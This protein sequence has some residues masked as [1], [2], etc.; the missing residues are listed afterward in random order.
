MDALLATTH[1]ERMRVVTRQTTSGAQ[2]NSLLR[3]VSCSIAGGRI[4]VGVVHRQTL[5][6]CLAT[7]HSRF[8]TGDITG[9]PIAENFDR[10]GSVHDIDPHTSHSKTSLEFVLYGGGVYK[11]ERGRKEKGRVRKGTDP[12]VI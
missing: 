10:G 12:L 3:L 7:L 5:L 6:T 11:N 8:H 9:V 4:G 1:I 2:R